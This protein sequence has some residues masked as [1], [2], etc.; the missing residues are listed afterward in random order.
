MIN[1]VIV[2]F[3]LLI[4]IIEFFFNTIRSFGF[5]FF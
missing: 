3:L 2:V 4:N 1:L 5:F